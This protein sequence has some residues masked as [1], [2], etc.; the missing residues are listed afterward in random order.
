MAI[1][2]DPVRLRGSKRLDEIIS[3]H[4]NQE[5]SVFYQE[6]HVPFFLMLM[7]VHP[8]GPA[9]S[10][11]VMCSPDSEF[12][13]TPDTIKGR[14]RDSQHQHNCFEFT[15]VLEGTMYQVVEGKRY[16]YPAGS[17]CLMNLNTLHTEELSTDFTCLFLSVSPGLIR[18]LLEMRGLMLFA[19]ERAVFE[20]EIFRFLKKNLN[21]GKT[22]NK[23][24]L[25][26]VPKITYTEQVKIVHQVFE[27]MLHTLLAP[28][29]GATCRILELLLR[30]IGILGQEKYYHLE[31]VD[32]HSN[33]ESLLFARIDRL[34]SERHGRITH[35]ELANILNYNGSYL[36]RIVKKYTGQCLFDYSMNFA[37]EYAAGQLR[38]TD[39]SIS[40]IMAELNFGNR[41]HFYKIFKEHYGITPQQYRE[42]SDGKCDAAIKEKAD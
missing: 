5:S 8:D 32:T 10:T 13:M 31:H 34:L 16:F 21:N 41:S 26:L 14:A 38:K 25:D 1:L 4:Q 12:Q 23:D 6:T 28:E 27:Q 17:C 29:A 30:L 2:V 7:S 9:E 39:R 3:F 24:F 11:L 37:M 22:N 35:T 15:Y 40:G 19:E 18:H 36:G 42:I 20:N 33:M